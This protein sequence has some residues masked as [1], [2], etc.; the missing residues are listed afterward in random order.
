[1]MIFLPAN[2]YFSADALRKPSLRLV[3]VPRFT[4]DTIKI[5]I[6]ILYVYAGLAKINSDWLL[7]A[8]PLRTWLPSPG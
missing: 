8:Q 5:I 3:Y 1:M 2:V 4:I 7:E 6:G